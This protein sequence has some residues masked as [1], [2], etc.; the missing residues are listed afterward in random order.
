MRSR[1]QRRISLCAFQILTRNSRKGHAQR[2]QARASIGP[3]G[4]EGIMELRAEDLESSQ[5]KPFIVLSS[6]F[7]KSRRGKTA[8]GF[9]LPRGILAAQL[10]PTDATP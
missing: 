9:I 7:I 3:E 4:F 10:T 5:L 2:G 6:A 8:V 1:P